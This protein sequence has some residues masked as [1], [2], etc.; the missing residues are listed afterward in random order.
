MFFSSSVPISTSFFNVFLIFILFSTLKVRKIM[1]SSLFSAFYRLLAITRHAQWLFL[2]GLVDWNF[3][4]KLMPLFS[5]MLIFIVFLYSDLKSF[6]TILSFLA[7]PLSAVVGRI[8]TVLFFIGIFPLYQ[9]FLF[10]FRF[11]YHPDCSFHFLLL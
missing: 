7:N 8:K 5:I 3:W 1:T 11:S 4:F 9:D 2:K 6:S 10:I